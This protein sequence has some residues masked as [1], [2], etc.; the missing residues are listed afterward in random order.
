MLVSW[1]GSGVNIIRRNS[2]RDGQ[3]P[4]CREAHGCARAASLVPY[5]KDQIAELIG[6]L[7]IPQIALS[8]PGR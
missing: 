7:R 1:W 2:L 6:I 8:A 3:E 5:V 4:E